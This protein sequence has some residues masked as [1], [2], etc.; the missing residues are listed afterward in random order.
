M[1]IMHSSEDYTLYT[2]TRSSMAPRSMRFGVR[3][4]KLMLV[5]HWMGDQKLIISNSFMLWKAVY[6]HQPAVGY[7]PF[8]LCV[9][10][11]EGLCPASGDINRLMT[12][13]M[14]LA[15]RTLRPFP[16]DRDR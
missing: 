7:G 5:C 4:R 15:Y 2:R 10:H 14:I 16:V 1:H 8:F 11:K 13:M 6:T 3:S 9:I 12:M